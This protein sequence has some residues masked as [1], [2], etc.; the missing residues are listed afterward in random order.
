MA[1]VSAGDDGLGQHARPHAAHPIREGGNQHVDGGVREIA[2]LKVAI[3]Q[4]ATDIYAILLSPADHQPK[5]DKYVF[6]VKTLLRSIDIFTQEILAND[7]ATALLYNQAI[8]HRTTL[9]AKAEK[10]LTKKQVKTLFDD[11]DNPDPFA[12]KRLLNLHVIRPAEELPIDSLQFSPVA[13][14]QIMAMGGEAARRALDAG[15]I[16]SL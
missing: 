9:R 5:P 7:V 12:G 8:R 11:P 6:L 2:P 10:L 13:M 14:S 1:R 4:G 3:D 15:P 16:V